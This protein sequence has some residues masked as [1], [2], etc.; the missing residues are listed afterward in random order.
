MHELKWY[1]AAVVIEICVAGD[2]RNVVHTNYYL[3]RAAT[4]EE[5]YDRAEALGR[6]EERQWQNPEGAEV[7]ARFWGI[8]DIQ[9][10]GDDFEDG[11]ELFYEE[12]I[13]VPQAEINSLLLNREVLGEENLNEWLESEFTKSPNYLDAEV[14]KELMEGFGKKRS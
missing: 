5:A 2:P 3:V 13:G 14:A 4:L 7:C 12:R 9:V 1:I 6:A 11:V 10:F 8:H